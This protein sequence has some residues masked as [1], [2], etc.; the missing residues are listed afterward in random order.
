MTFVVAEE[1]NVKE[2]RGR[3]VDNDGSNE[4]KKPKSVPKDTIIPK[5]PTQAGGESCC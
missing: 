2:K 5:C 4:R 1:A 3:T